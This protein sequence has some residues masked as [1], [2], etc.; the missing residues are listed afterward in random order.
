MANER[1]K[2]FSNDWYCIYWSIIF[3]Y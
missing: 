1:S 2:D 3:S